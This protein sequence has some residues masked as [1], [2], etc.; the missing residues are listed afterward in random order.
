M[1][2]LCGPR[3]PS[4]ACGFAIRAGSRQKKHRNLLGMSYSLKRV[5]GVAIG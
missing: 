4:F 2:L 5:E 1:A 3:R